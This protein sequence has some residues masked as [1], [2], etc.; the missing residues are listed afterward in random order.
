MGPLFTSEPLFVKVLRE[1]SLTEHKIC[2][3]LLKHRSKVLMLAVF[4]E[5]LCFWK[6]VQTN[7]NRDL[8][9][10]RGVESTF[11][12]FQVLIFLSSI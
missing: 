6:S 4:L 9:S 11:L 1:E 10:S 12:V 5:K 7:W 8:R 3:V 2:G